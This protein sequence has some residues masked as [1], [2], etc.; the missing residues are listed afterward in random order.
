VILTHPAAIA[1]PAA[2]TAANP[3]RNEFFP[4]DLYSDVLDWA[5]YI[6]PLNIFPIL[7]MEPPGQARGPYMIP[8]RQGSGGL[9]AS[10]LAESTEAEHS[11]FIPG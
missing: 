10:Q 9:S 7:F 2:R 8:L 3:Q 1:R 6:V 11:A 4:M 5:S